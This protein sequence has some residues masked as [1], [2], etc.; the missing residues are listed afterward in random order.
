MAK[1]YQN[2]IDEARTLTQDTD[3]DGYRNTTATYID[4]LNRALQELARL[5]PD[6][7]YDQFATDDVVIP[8][9]TDGTLSTDFL[10]PMMFYAAVI[11]YIV[12]MIEIIDD[13][14]SV[15]G[16]AMAMLGSF[17]QSVVGL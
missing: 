9:I 13:E 5:R 11:A 7:F 10:P 1:T 6:A 14:F 16:R 17:K 15:D 3:A 12:G 8:E 2:V 4:Q